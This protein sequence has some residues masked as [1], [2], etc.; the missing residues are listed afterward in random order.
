MSSWHSYP[1]IYAL[2]HSAI[3]ELFS[4]PV[5]VQEKVDGSQ[6]SFGMID[7]VLHCRSKGVE[8]Q[9]DA[10]DKLFSAAIETVKELAPELTPG[11]TYRGE[12]LSKPKHN[13]LAYER[14]PRK[15]IILFDINDGQESYLAPGAVASEAERLDLEVV[16]THE[17]VDITSSAQLTELMRLSSSLG[18]PR[19][20]L[21]FKNYRR[22]GPDGKVL[23]GKMVSEEF[24]E[25]HEASWGESNPSTKDIIQAIGEGLRTQARW[26]KA[27]QKMMEAGTLTDSPRDIGELFKL[28]KAD[29]L[30]E[31]RQEISDK[32]FDYAKDHILRVSTGGLP[33][34]YKDYLAKKQLGEV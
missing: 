34:W 14:I 1:K 15:H 9:L 16:S 17:G 11:W 19:E 29:I 26:M 24:K 31:C 25:V 5:T 12:Y 3:K 33:Q 27:R 10:P 32:L 7:G 20:G 18:G 8:Q 28:V 21:V 4:D 23:M 2:G 22:F 30:E 6:F 13:A